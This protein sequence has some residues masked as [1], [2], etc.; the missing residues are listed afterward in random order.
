MNVLWFSNTPANSSE[1]FNQ[2]L[3][4]T[5]GWLKALDRRLQTDVDLHIAFYHD[6]NIKPFEYG[7]TKYYPI[8]KGKD[9]LIKSYYHGVTGKIIYDEDVS[10]YLNIINKI[11][12]DII[13]IHGTENPFG[14]IIER[15]NIPVVISIQGNI[16]VYHHKYMSGF[17]KKYLDTTK[18]IFHRIVG[19]TPFRNIYRL[20]KHMKIREGYALSKCRYIIGRTEW[21]RRISS[22]LAS[23]S[24]YFH[25]DEILRDEFYNNN[26]R[27]NKNTKYT[28]FTTNGNSY[29]KG[30]ETICHTIM[31]LREVGFTNY[32]WQVAGLT[33]KDL[34]YKTAKK[35]YKGQFPSKNLVVVGKLNEIELVGCLKKSDLYVMPSHIENS[36]NNL[37]E[38]MILGLPCI[39]TFAGGTG[40]LIRDGVDGML[41]QDGDPWA[42]AGAILELAKDPDHAGCLG[43]NARESALRRHNIETIVKATKDSYKSIIQDFHKVNK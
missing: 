26:W 40:S 16:T 38:A 6:E 31:L 35:K 9:S 12:P 2:S 43:S 22:I 21:D 10:K 33:S 15:V 7:K 36:P 14:Y 23:K 39:A 41:I 37:C 34:I 30:F 42:M 1:Y 17:G 27:A 4:G 24:A 5:G 8:Y 13:H 18:N 3:K 20:F 25:C 19:Y 28:I 32:E 11:N 29:Y